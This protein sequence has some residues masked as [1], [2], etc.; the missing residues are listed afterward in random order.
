MR[1]LIPAGTGQIVRDQ[2]RNDEPSESNHLDRARCAADQEISGKAGERDDAA[3]KARRDESAM[4]RRSQHVALRGRM[5]QRVNIVTNR[6]K[7]AQFPIARPA[8]Q[9]RPFFSMGAIVSEA[10]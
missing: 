7:Q 9:T 8:M 5:D 3:E 1:A 2:D 6:R 4:A 10:A